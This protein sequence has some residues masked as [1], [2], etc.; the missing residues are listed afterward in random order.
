MAVQSINTLQN[1]DNYNNIAQEYILESLANLGQRYNVQGDSISIGEFSLDKLFDGLVGSINVKDTVLVVDKDNDIYNIYLKTKNENGV[2][3]RTL[4]EQTLSTT[5]DNLSIIGPFNLENNPTIKYSALEFNKKDVDYI[6]YCRESY[7]TTVDKDNFILEQFDKNTD[8]LVKGVRIFKKHFND[9]FQN[10]YILIEVNLRRVDFKYDV[11]IYVSKDEISGS[12]DNEIYNLISNADFDFTSLFIPININYET[13]DFDNYRITPSLGLL[14]IFENPIDQDILENQLLYSFTSDST[15]LYPYLKERYCEYNFGDIKTIY[16]KI[17]KNL[18]DKVYED[19]NKDDYTSS[20]WE[21]ISNKLKLYIPLVT[22]SINNNIEYYTIS[23]A[24]NTNKP[25]VLYFAGK[26]IDVRFIEN[27]LDDDWFNTNF[28]D[29]RGTIIAHTDKC[30]RVS[31]YYFETNLEKLENNIEDIDVKKISTLPYIDKNGYWVIN[32]ISTGIYARGRSAGNPNIII[33]ETTNNNG[34]YNIISGAR[35]DELLTQLTW[36]NKIAKVEPLERINLD[37]LTFKNEFDYFSVNCSI[38]NL[39]KIPEVDKQEYLAQLENAIIICITPVS[40]INYDTNNNT[41]NINYTAQDVLD[42]YGE[43]GIIT[44]L[45]T[46]NDNYEFDYLRKRNN[47]YAAADFNY[48]SNINNLIQYAIKNHEPLHPDNYEFTNLV[49]DSINTSLKNN[50]GERATYIYPNLVNKLSKQYTNVSNYNNDVNFT[51]KANNSITHSN[52]GRN[53]D[54]IAQGGD[55]RYYNATYN[56]SDVNS[57]NVVT[58]SLYNHYENGVTQRY[59]EYIPN[60][61]V[62]SLDL[63]EVITRN[64]TLLNRLNIISFNSQGTAYLSYIGTSFENEKN[65][66]TIGTSKTNINMGTDTLISESDKSTFVEH[67]KLEINLDD[68]KINGET[69]VND[70]LNVDKNIYLNG[71][72]WQKNNN[73]VTTHTTINNTTYYTGI[74]TP[75]SRYIYELDDNKNTT[76][77]VEL[78]PDKGTYYE[79]ETSEPIIEDGVITGYKKSGKLTSFK[80]VDTN[81]LSLL[82]TEVYDYAYENNKLYTITTTPEYYTTSIG[83][84]NHKIYFSDG[85]YLPVLLRQLGLG[86][87]IK[88]IHGIDTKNVVATSNM[89][90]ISVNNSQILLLSSSTNLYPDKYFYSRLNTVSEDT[91]IEKITNFTYNMFTAN[92]IKITYYTSGQKLYI[93]LEELYSK[94][95]FTTTKKLKQ[96]YS[97]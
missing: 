8:T 67:D 61:N 24:Y 45:W 93:H 60:Y 51:F 69:T 12:S 92:P 65:V 38:P 39:D 48:L 36:E 21:E 27:T 17:L 57:A 20:E 6:F 89:E 59:N 80:D 50:T 22:S 97:I 35:K 88:T 73:V 44:T 64:E 68:V 85:I 96:N 14:N 10:H 82:D 63:S 72:V 87:Y 66:L 37:N 75:T 13:C 33:V 86:K 55:V 90:I 15:N 34:G 58:N 77:L 49:F 71:V 62:P 5:D 40:C 76:G 30:E 53:I 19:Y 1:K 16:K 41:D 42:I 32:D 84:S 47:E 95:K 3:E 9:S 54:Y 56:S 28:E 7:T 29:Y 79:E 83:T 11:K 18:Y 94:N 25:E 23:Y 46:I 78:F 91:R 31:F 2:W 81:L 26:E 52:D 70:N 74:V 4:V 43:Y